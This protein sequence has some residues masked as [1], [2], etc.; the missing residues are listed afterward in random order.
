MS[1]LKLGLTLA[2]LLCLFMTTD[3]ALGLPEET[4]LNLQQ[5]EVITSTT[6]SIEDD[7]SEFDIKELI[8]TKPGS[9][10]T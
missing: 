5:G 9:K 1:A 2:L 3:Y 7:S 10:Q 4:S 8:K 6:L